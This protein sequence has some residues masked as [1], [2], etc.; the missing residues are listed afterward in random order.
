MVVGS[1]FESD[2]LMFQFK[3]HNEMPFSFFLNLDLGG[4]SLVNVF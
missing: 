2:V 4:I 1:I 3:A